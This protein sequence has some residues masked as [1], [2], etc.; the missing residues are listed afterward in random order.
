MTGIIVSSESM[1][2]RK[3][4]GKTRVSS[5]KLTLRILLWRAG[6]YE[7]GESAKPFPT[8]YISRNSP[9]RQSSSRHDSN[10]YLIGCASNAHTVQSSTFRSSMRRSS[11]TFIRSFLCLTAPHANLDLTT[12]VAFIFHNTLNN[13]FIYKSWW[14]LWSARRRMVSDIWRPA[15]SISLLD[16]SVIIIYIH[17]YK[18]MSFVWTHV[19]PSSTWTHRRQRM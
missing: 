19:Y 16:L 14:K 12:N 5:G 9:P 17:N 11:Y 6:V 4:S 3:D 15:L 1:T 13:N 18:K 2:G 10:I 8:T 7:L